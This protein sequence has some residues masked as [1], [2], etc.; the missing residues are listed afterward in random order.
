MT[1]LN[2]RIEIRFHRDAAGFRSVYLVLGTRMRVKV[3]RAKRMGSGWV[4]FLA[5]GGGRTSE[6]KIDAPNSR[7]FRAA[8]LA[9]LLPSPKSNVEGVR[10]AI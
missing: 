2:N 5:M 3:G 4:G 1:T 6:V 10:F 9:I 7:E 8:A